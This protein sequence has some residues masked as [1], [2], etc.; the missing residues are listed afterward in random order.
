MAP[1]KMAEL[2]DELNLPTTVT[3]RVLEK[4]LANARKRIEVRETH[5]TI[6][7]ALLYFE[8]ARNIVAGEELLYDY[9][10]KDRGRKVGKNGCI[11][12]QK[13]LYRNVNTQVAEQVNSTIKRIHGSISY[14]NARNCMTHC[15]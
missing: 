5:A 6:V 13:L 15:S 9:G 14:M 4:R 2:R 1:L 8:V 12:P 10:D 7:C 11:Y 3:R